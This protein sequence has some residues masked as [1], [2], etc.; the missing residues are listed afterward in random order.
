MITSQKAPRKRYGLF[1]LAVLILL[2]GGAALYVGSHDFM[3]RSLGLVAILVSVY[4][5][6]ISHVHDR[7]DFSGTSGRSADIKAAK[8]PGRLLWIVSLALL[9]ILAASYLY[10]DYVAA[11]G[12]YTGLPAYLFAG[13]IVICATVWGYLATRMIQ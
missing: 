7:S 9:P 10:M 4:L 1:I 8:G 13:V 5:V 11:H 6:R 12:G 2:S 3:I